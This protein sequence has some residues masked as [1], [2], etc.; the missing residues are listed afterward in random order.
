MINVCEQCPLRLFNIRGH[1]ISGIG[2][3]WSGNTLVL[4]NVDKSAYKKQDMS[5]SSQI[6]I[7]QNILP[8][9]GLEQNLYVIP[10][11]RCNEHFDIEITQRIISRCYR[12]FEEDASTYQLKNIMLCGDAARHMLNIDDLKPYLDTVI[13]DKATQRRY[14]INYSPLVKYTNNERFEVFKSRLIKYYNS[15]MS[16]IY[17][18][19]IMII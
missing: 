10:L 7:L 6:E 4:P 3:T 19:E 17:D 5:F 2:N 9:G 12:Y 16:K 11:I 15:V 8:T 1:N 18:Y 14:F 13:C